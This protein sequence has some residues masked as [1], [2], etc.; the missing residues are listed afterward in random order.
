MTVRQ[1]GTIGLRA[2]N[3]TIMQNVP[4]YEQVQEGGSNGKTV[5]NHCDDYNRAN[6]H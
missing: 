5:T 3:G 6:N 4:I 2:P 1:I